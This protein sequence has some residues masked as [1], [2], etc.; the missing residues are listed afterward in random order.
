M[1][2]LVKFLTAETVY[3]VRRC[4]V[5]AT[6]KKRYYQAQ[7]DIESELLDCTSSVVPSH[8]NN[9]DILERK[10]NVLVLLLAYPTLTT[11]VSKSS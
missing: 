5:T 11:K 7:Y 1:Q 6:E 2:D 4:E 9:Y 3:P 10:Y 8:P